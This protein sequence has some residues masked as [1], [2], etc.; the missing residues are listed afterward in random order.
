[1]ADMFVEAQA[2]RVID[3]WKAGNETGWVTP[4]V[5]YDPSVKDASG[6]VRAPT[7]KAVKYWVDHGTVGTNTLR[8]WGEG[9]SVANKAWSLANYLVPHEQ[10]Q[11]ADG[12]MHDTSHV[13]FKM[14]PDGFACNQTGQTF[15]EISNENSMGV[16][17]ESLQNGT[18]DISESQLTRGALITAH[19]MRVHAVIDAFRISH[20]WIA[21]P[22]G[23]RTDPWAGKFDIAHSWELIQAIRRDPRIWQFWGL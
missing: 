19:D 21:R 6:E 1:M 18:S 14:V 12:H 22:W 5:L 15:Q 16:E 7:R 4:K 3:V 17:Y 2:L 9:G 23:R 13:V 8:F 10:T 11:Y 20:G